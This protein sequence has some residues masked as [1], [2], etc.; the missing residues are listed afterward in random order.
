MTDTIKQAMSP[1]AEG[2]FRVLVTEGKP[3]SIKE[4]VDEINKSLP[5]QDAVSSKSVY[6]AM[7]REWLKGNYCFYMTD[8]K[9][10]P[11]KYN[12]DPEY[13]TIYDS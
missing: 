6:G 3:L 8:E 7:Y 9:V 2:I 1:L 10:Q 13:A 11:P 4:I 12:V 5:P